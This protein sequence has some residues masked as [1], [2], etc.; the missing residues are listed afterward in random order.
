MT[1][2][3]ILDAALKGLWMVFS[4]PNIVYPVAGTLLA[5]MFAVMPGLGGATLMAL[6]IP[7]TFGWDPLPTMLLFGA[8][9][10]GATF[11]GSVSA[12]LFGIP[13]GSSNAATMFDGY[14]MAQQG[15]AK[16]AI[17]C[18]ASASAL[19]S[20]FGICV[21]VLLI[22]V[23]REFIL[24]LGPPEFLML[25]VWGLTTLAAL[26]RDSLIKGLSTACFG[27][28]LAFAGLDPRTAEVRYAF[29]SLYLEDGLDIVPVFLGMF[30]LTQMMELRVSGRVTVSGKTR[31]EEL[32]GSVW[33]GVTSVFSHF[34]LFLRSSMIGAVVGIIPGI[35]ATLAGFLAYGHAVQTAG[36]DRSRFGRGDIRGVLAPEAANDAKD[37]GA[38][39]PTLAL[40]IPGGTGTAV[41]LAVLTLHGLVP[42]KEMF[43]DHLPLVFALI[44]SLFLSNWLTS[45]LGLAAIGP[46]A[47]LTTTRAQPL[48]F[49][50]VVV[51]TAGAYVY[52]GRM[53]DVLA[54]FVFGVFGYYLNKHHWPRIPLVIGLVLGPL[55]ER[56]FHITRQLQRLGRIDFWSR[57]AA[58]TLLALTLLSLAVSLWPERGRRATTDRAK[59]P[60]GRSPGT[61]FTALLL[62]FAGLLW[63]LTL[64]LG[65]V[66]RLVPEWVVVPLLLLLLIQTL[67]DSPPGIG[68]RGDRRGLIRWLRI[69]QLLTKAGSRSGRGPNAHWTFRREWGAF[70]WILLVPVSVY[71]FGF[72]IAVPGSVLFY[73]KRAE[74]AGWRESAILAAIL[75]LLIHGVFTLLP[76]IRPYPGQLVNWLAG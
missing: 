52:R 70:R 44:W 41:F 67:L 9:V 76:G 57:P 55:F 2:E 21:F 62:G 27:L 13:G 32:T 39:V 72:L 25:A 12:I 58:M 61:L 48:T 74:G 22:P 63:Y 51:V 31:V 20:T 50:I 11:M 18:S 60:G 71:A 29:G 59:V 66:A 56:N 37:G 16:T 49:A 5:M 75:G 69:E 28:L 38:L 4:W 47:R 23:M 15:R 7:F 24:I 54:A 45:I 1:L 40:G 8:F 46:L 26:T 35:G 34:G 14:P 42:G 43:T 10:G 17:G 6:A 3:P 33:E 73:M 68:E 53:E 30:A 19:G 65:P 64:G 36:R